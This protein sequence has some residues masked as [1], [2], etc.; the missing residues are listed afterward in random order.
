MRFPKGPTRAQEKAKK[1]TAIEAR[2]ASS[3]RAVE[4]R[5]RMTCRACGVAVR[6]TADLDLRRIEHHH[7]RGRGRKDSEATSN[8]AVLCKGCHDQRHAERSLSI[9]GNADSTLRFERNGRVWF[10]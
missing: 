4:L 5:D 7:V 9:T 8:L 3:Y 10:G 2:R 1:R 6:K